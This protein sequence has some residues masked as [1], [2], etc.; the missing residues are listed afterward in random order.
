MVRVTQKL[1]V[2]VFIKLHPFGC[3]SWY[4]ADLV[5]QRYVYWSFIPVYEKNTKPPG[6]LRTFVANWHV[7]LVSSFTLLIKVRR[8]KSCKVQQQN[9]KV[10]VYS[11]PTRKSIM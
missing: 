8:N 1:L 9:T 4:V 2:W 6:V 11:T 10:F 5:R 7:E 3:S